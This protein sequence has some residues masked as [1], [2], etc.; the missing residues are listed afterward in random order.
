MGAWWIIIFIIF[1]FM[2]WG[3]NGFG[4]Y[5]NEGNGS[6]GSVMDAY[7]LNSDFATLQRQMDS[8]F[9]RIGN[10]IEN[11]NNGLCDGFY[12]VNTAFGNLNTTLCTQFGN[13][14][15]AIT[16]NGYESRLATQGLS[17]QLASCCCDLRQQIADSSCATQRAIDGVN[18]N[19]AMNT[20]AIQQTLCNNTRDIIESNNANYRALHDEIIA[21]R[22]EDKNAQIQAQQ[23]EI[24]R[25]QLA[26]SQER[27]NNYL[28]DQLKP[29]PIPAY[30]TCN[31]YQSYPY[32]YGYNNNGCNSGCNCGN[33]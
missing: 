32:N 25:L 10:R 9:D 14:I 23:N 13:T 24:S 21:N 4:G 26:A 7:V 16:Q 33:F 30:I 19:N 1:A 5:G 6:N 31:P 2:G 18:Y 8:G 17:S 15:N 29:C 20:N 27:Q 12:S 11:V 28:I 3:R 22:I